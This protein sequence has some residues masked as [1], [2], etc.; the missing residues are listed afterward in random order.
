[1]AIPRRSPVIA[2]LAVL[3]IP[4][5]EGCATKAQTGT[6]VGAAGGAVV[7]GAIGRATGSTS[8]GAII[9]AIVGGTAGAII[10]REMDKQA[11]ELEQNIKGARV[12]RVGEGIHVTFESGLLFDFDSDRVRPEAQTNLQELANSLGQ[13]PNTDLVIVGHTDAVGSAAYNQGLSER[14]ARSASMV[15]VAR[16]VAP[17]RLKTSGLGETEPVATND[18]EAGRAANRR[19]EVAIFAS[20]AYRQQLTRSTPP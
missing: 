10:G 14:R 6:V 11:R 4:G 18:T 13:Y 1:M 17:A 9:G 8:R 5:L 3:A 12:E 15:L 20:E 19:V 7:G 16:G 2:L